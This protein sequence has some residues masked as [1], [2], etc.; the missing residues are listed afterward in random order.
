MV[1]AV[2]AA[3]IALFVSERMRMDIVA[4]LVLVALKLLGLVTPT[5]AVSGFS[6]PAVITV[7]A[8]FI[9]SGSLSRT[10]WPAWWAARSC[11]WRA[12]GRRGSSS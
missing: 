4:L 6:N 11:A 5:E 3:A 2:L 7:G 1:L 12:E 8:V 10:G 9:L